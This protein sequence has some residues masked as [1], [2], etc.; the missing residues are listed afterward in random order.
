M[1]LLRECPFCGA[2]L[3]PGER[4]D[5]QDEAGGPGRYEQ[6][7]MIPPGEKF[8]FVGAERGAGMKWHEKCCEERR[9]SPCGRNDK[10]N[11]GSGAGTP[12][13]AKADD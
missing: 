4:C 5:C 1:S 6:P 7:T 3:D 2:A 8:I 10:E 13:P 11:A 12:E 9:I